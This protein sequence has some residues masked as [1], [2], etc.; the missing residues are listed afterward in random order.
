MGG[1]TFSVKALLGTSPVLWASSDPLLVRRSAG[2]SNHG[3]RLDRR[4][5]VI[6]VSNNMKVLL[7][8]YF[9]AGMSSRSIGG[10][11]MCNLTEK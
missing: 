7:Y 10:T 3:R 4:M 11:E 5:A 6:I 2:S 1:Q 9:N 8:Q